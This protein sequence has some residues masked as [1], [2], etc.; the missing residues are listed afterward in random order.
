MRPMYIKPE[1]ALQRAEELVAV[2]ASVEALHVLEDTL[3]SRR[4]RGAP[5]ASVEPL[6][7]RF[8]E[9]AVDLNR[10]LSARE[11]LHS[12]KNLAQNTSVGSVE[13]VVRRFL[14]YSEIKLKD[15][16]EAKAAKV[17]AAAAAADEEV[18][19][20]EAADTFES[21]YATMINALDDGAA[22][23]ATA[24]ATGTKPARR[25]RDEVTPRLKFLW[26]AY[27]TVLDVLRNNARLELLYQQTVA[28]AFAFCKINA[29]KNEFRR[30]CETLRT[31]LANL[32]RQASQH[33]GINLSDPEV[34]QRFLDTR[35]LQL[36]TANDMELWQES[37]RS[38]EDIYQLLVMAGNLIAPSNPNN[39]QPMAG[40]LPAALFSHKRHGAKMMQMVAQYYEKMTRIFA[41]S[42]D[43]LFQAA[44]WNMYH[45]W[46]AGIKGAQSLSD[47]EH[48]T[49]AGHVVLSALAAPVFAD[50]VDPEAHHR[51]NRKQRLTQML[52]LA[53][54]PDRASLLGSATKSVLARLPAVVRDLYEALEP[55]FHPLTVA[56]AVRPLLA[57]LEAEPEFAKY[58]PHLR[59]VTLAKVLQSVS[60]LYSTISFETIIELTSVS[61]SAPTDM[62]TLEAAVLRGNQK[63]EF[64]VTLNYLTQSLEFAAEAETPDLQS[65]FRLPLYAKYIE[66]EKHTI[67]QRAREHVEEEHQAAL[68]RQAVLEQKKIAQEQAAQRKAAEE[69]KER[70]R[71]AQEEREALQKKMAEDAKRREL[72]RLEA[73]KEVIRK[74]EARRIAEAL[75][76]KS[77]V[78]I[79]DEDLDKMDTT[80]IFALQ[81]EQVRKEREE[82]EAKMNVQ[83]KR[84][85]YFERAM[86]K[87]EIPLLHKAHEEQK[88]ADRAAFD[89]ARK[90]T[91]EEAK[92]RHA[93]AV[94]IKHRVLPMMD[95]YNEYRTKVA[96]VAIAQ[97]EAQKEE[98]AAKLAAAK[99]ERR[100][101][102]RAFI[103][104]KIAAKK[105]AE[106]ADRKRRLEEAL[107]AEREGLDDD[108]GLDDEFFRSDNEDEEDYPEEEN[109]D[110]SAS[111]AVRNAAPAAGRSGAWAPP[112]RRGDAPAAAAGPAKWTPGSGSGSAAPAWGARPAAA[113]EPARGGAW[114]P[115]AR[116]TDS[117]AAGAAPPARGGAWTPGAGRA[118]SGAGP[119]PAAGRPTGAWTPSGG[120][121]PAPR[122]E[123]ASGWRRGGDSPA[124]GGAGTPP[125]AAS[126][127][128]A[129][130]PRRG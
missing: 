7:L 65:L 118:A 106:E 13:R 79:A 47:A 60:S 39:P 26:D 103:A 3:K 120:A 85:D 72:E 35:F 29:R 89:E 99:A 45:G 4:T 115:G 129:W 2:N 25:E 107:A 95:D 110:R 57:Q 64:A 62:F 122:A 74:Q 114:T 59:Q 130:R 55:A 9:L 77:G 117:P 83:T 100:D 92:E 23:L 54:I 97:H 18:D 119:A 128:G 96:S 19:D 113:A 76:A 11:A 91:V 111:P 93:T 58:V 101:A 21:V 109:R 68:A 108:E 34:L 94:A 81:A 104:K 50:V 102:A 8:I 63:N 43:R 22:D 1:N 86:R 82:I 46:V 88:I 126:S 52:G 51:F 69:A 15:A 27:R 53:V 30:L 44:A 37:F 12:F 61:E 121:A 10:G 67:F 105:E 124:A 90:Q 66:E 78:T 112:S 127:G 87:E 32:P 20:L 33:N 48:Q 5:I 71:K 56:E 40:L 36:Q 123:G 31:H 17:A 49:V 98:A 84:M 24:L 42:E 41:V 38:A 70:A 125:P 14:E 28:Q 80:A 73:E 16:K 6:A 75:K 116:R